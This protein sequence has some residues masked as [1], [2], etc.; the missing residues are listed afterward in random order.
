MREGNLP[1]F[2]TGWRRERE[3]T[4]LSFHVAVTVYTFEH[5]MYC[6]HTLMWHSI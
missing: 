2:L 1:P 6:A 4:V 3:D 5:M